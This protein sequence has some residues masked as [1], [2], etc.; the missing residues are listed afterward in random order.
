MGF[1]I[2]LDKQRCTQVEFKLR[3]TVYNHDGMIWSLYDVS[4]FDTQ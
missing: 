3:Y 2:S 4:T 1:V